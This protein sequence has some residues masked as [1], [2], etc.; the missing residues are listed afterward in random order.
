MP[1]ATNLRA[2]PGC[3]PSA[4]PKEDGLSGPGGVRPTPPV[5]PPPPSTLAGPKGPS[6]EG[7]GRVGAPGGAGGEAREDLLPTPRATRGEAA[8]L[9]GVRTPKGARTRGGGGA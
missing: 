7:D 8:A 3:P 4:P 2:A 9:P 5:A 6:R 1:S